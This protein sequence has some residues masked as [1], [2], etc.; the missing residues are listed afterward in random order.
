VGLS[1][2]FKKGFGVYPPRE[3]LVG[4][5]RMR[6]EEREENTWLGLYLREKKQRK[7]KNRNV[8]IIQR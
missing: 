3:I 5:S 1:K 2:W 4:S 7:G 6:K 8:I